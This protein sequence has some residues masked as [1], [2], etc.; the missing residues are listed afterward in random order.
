MITLCVYILY[1]RMHSRRVHYCVHLYTYVAYSSNWVAINHSPL[2]LPALSSLLLSLS[3]PLSSL[4]LTLSQ[5]KLEVS[6]QRQAMRVIGSLD[7][8]VSAAMLTPSIH[9]AEGGADDYDD[10]ELGIPEIWYL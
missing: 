1:V 9:V 4:S 6:F 3:L 2:T 5:V 8:V 10:M 7:A